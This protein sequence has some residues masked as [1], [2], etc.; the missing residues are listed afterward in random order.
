M[1]E[2]A[3]R[4]Y[5][6]AGGEAT[7]RWLG[8]TSTAFLATGDSTAG[9]FALVDERARKGEA[10]PLHRHVEDLEAFYVVEGQVSFFVDGASGRAVGAG[11]FVYVPPGVVH[12]FRVASETAR[13]L[14]LTTPHHGA[15]YEAITLPSGPAGER[16]TGSLPDGHIRKAAVEFGIEFVGPL[17]DTGDPDA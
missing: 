2:V 3:A 15:F 4:P 8:D 17:P 12:G 1:T 13:Y 11:S 7:V 14:I 6:L 10:V 16:P 9:A 5:V